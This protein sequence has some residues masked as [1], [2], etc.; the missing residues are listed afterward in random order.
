MKLSDLENIII[1]EIEN[2][3]LKESSLSRVHKHIME[4]DCAIISAQR[5]DPTDTSRCADSGEQTTQEEPGQKP[6]PGPLNRKNTRDL[7]A[8][9]LSLGYGVTAVDGSYIENFKT[10]QA[11]EVQEDSFFVANLKKDSSFYENIKTLGRKFCQD[12]VLIIPQGGKGAYL[13]GTNKSDFPGLDDTVSVGDL[14]MGEEAEF[15]TKVRKRP[16]TFNET[17]LEEYGSLSRME[18][19][20]VKTIA[21]K[22]LK[23]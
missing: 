3:L 23:V 8:T 12:S 21:K 10:P 5:K 20:A 19:M 14:K 7:K 2:V 18:K 13:Y 4:N 6:T 11:V 17:L 22:V 9:L 1:E 15:M 16:F